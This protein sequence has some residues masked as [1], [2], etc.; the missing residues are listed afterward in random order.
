VRKI[1]HPDFVEDFSLL[2]DLED[3]VLAANAEA[4]CVQVE[5]AGVIARYDQATRVDF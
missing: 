5:G 4:G 1:P 3:I 2:L